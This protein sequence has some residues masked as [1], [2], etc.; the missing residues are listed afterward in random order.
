MRRT[1][2]VGF[3]LLAMPWSALAQSGPYLA[4]VGDAEV[5]LRAGPSDQFPE[6]ATL[7]PGSQVVVDHEE[8]NGWLAVMDPPGKAYSMSWILGTYIDFDNTKPAPQAVMVHGEATLAAG[9]IGEKQPL[10]IRKTK[11]PA[12]TAL[13]VIGEKVNFENRWWYPVI[14]PAGDFRYL[15]GQAVKYDKPAA[16]NVV[17]RGSIPGAAGGS[18]SL[19]PAAIGGGS[20]PTA[21]N[22]STATAGTPP[23]QNPLWDQ[24]NTAEREGRLDDAEKLYFQLA[25]VMNQPGGDHDVANLCYTRIHTLREKKR[26]AGGGLASSTSRPAPGAQPARSGSLPPDQRDD[27]GRWSGPGKL[28]R[29]SLVLD[30]RSTYALLSDRGDTICYVLAARGVDLNRQVGKRVELYGTSATYRGLSK[31]YVVAARVEP[32]Q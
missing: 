22:G 2:L 1:L 13:L 7:M 23:V 30:G 8:G 17:V 11:V 6:T 15:P 26:A 25:Q 32:V 9:K 14:P 24:A 10:H 28:V 4:T 5:K 18:S 12:G 16:T 31:P 27:G 21:G 20:R 19:P 3:A 29:S